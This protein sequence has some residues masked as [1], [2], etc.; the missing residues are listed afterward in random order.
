[1]ERRA[2]KRHIYL[3][4]FCGAD[5]CL[6]QGYETGMVIQGW[7]NIVIFC[8]TDRNVLLLQLLITGV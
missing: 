5:F 4:F 2:Q 1:M 7:N 3:G 8:G 6:I